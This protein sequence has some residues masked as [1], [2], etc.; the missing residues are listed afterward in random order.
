MEKIQKKI[1]VGSGLK[2]LN[3]LKKILLSL[4]A[5]LSSS[6]FTASSRLFPHLR[7]IIDPPTARRVFRGLLVTA[8]AAMMADPAAAGFQTKKKSI[9][10]VPVGFEFGGEVG[11]FGM[12]IILLLLFAGI[13]ICGNQ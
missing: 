7:S 1:F 12:L 3:L 8:L 9:V 5:S 10:S 6:P 4:S 11:V 13:W 2:I